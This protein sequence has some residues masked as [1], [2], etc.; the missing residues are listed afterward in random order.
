MFKNKQGNSII[1]V[2]VVIVILTVGIIGTYGILNGGQKLSTTGEN[3]VKA[4]NIAREGMEAV[5]NIRDTNWIKFSG[6]YTNCWKSKDYN[7]LCIGNLTTDYIF[8]PG[9]YVLVQSGMFWTL[10]G[11]IT[12]LPYDSGYMNQFAVYLDSHGLTSHSGNNTLCSFLKTTDC[13]TIF[14]REIQITHPDNDHMKVNS[15]VKWVDASKISEPY[16]INLETTFTNW[17]K[18]F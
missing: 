14:T 9:S 18:K 5:E 15:I 4:I 11:T 1:E 6:D 16:T 2:M 12:P 8:S 7:P 13:K 3:R 10:S 17:K